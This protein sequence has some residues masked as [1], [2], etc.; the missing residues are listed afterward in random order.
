MLKD[1]HEENVQLPEPRSQQSSCSAL[2]ALVS[3]FVYF[4]LFWQATCKIS[5][6][7]LEWLLRFMFQFIHSLGVTCSNE[8]LIQMAAIFPSSLYLLRSIVKLDRDSFTKY[9]VCPDCTKLY[10]LDRCTMRV[11]NRIESRRCTNQP[12]PSKKKE[13]GALLARKVVTQQNNTVFYPFKVYCFNSVI[14]QL[15]SILKRPGMQSQCEKWRKRKV[16]HGFMADIF[17]GQMWKDFQTCQGKDFLRAKNN[18]A[19][20]INVDWFQP[21]KRRKDRSVGVIYFVILNLPREERYKWENVIVTGIIPELKKEPKS[22]NTFL[23]P[24]V[25]E[26]NALW[27]GIRLQTSSSK[28]PEHYRA[29][30]ILASSDIPASRKLCGFKGHSAHRGCSKCFKFFPGSF[31]QKTDYSGF[32]VNEW[33]LRDNQSHRRNALKVKNAQNKT[34]KEKLAKKY[35]VYFS[36][37]LDLEYFDAVRFSVVDPMHNLFLG[38]SKHIFKTWIKIGVLDNKALQ[39]L[40]KRILQCDVPTGHGRLPNKIASNYGCYTASQWKNWTLIYSIYCLKGLIPD[41]HFKCWQT[42]VLA[43]QHMSKHYICRNDIVLADGLFIKFCKQVEILFGKDVITPNM[44]LHCHMKNCVLDYGPLHAFWCFSFE[45]FN[46]ILGA[47]QMNGRSI[48]IQ[49]MRKF[50]TSKF[51]W[52][53]ELP[54]QFHDTFIP[55]FKSTTDIDTEFS[56]RIAV[57]FSTCS[58]HHN[59]TEVKWDDLQLVGLAKSFQYTILDSDDLNLLLDCY[60]QLHNNLDDIN[61]NCLSSTIRKYSYIF[62]GTEKFGSKKDNKSLR[63]SRVM[64]CWSDEDGKINPSAIARPGQVKYYFIHSLTV[65]GSTKQFAFASVLWHSRDEDYAKYG[66]PSMIWRQNE[67]DDPG[68]ASFM[69]VQRIACS[70]AQCSITRNNTKKIVVTPI[71]RIYN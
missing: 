38:T 18:L 53:S 59:L 58:I 25:N 70:F 27:K 33:P 54:K 22:L 34:R 51:T 39:E 69:P 30:V 55:F 17:D 64:A 10:E 3:W 37:L 63:S 41:E 15:E 20:G 23:G 6:N 68:P 71:S 28:T 21:Y 60:K 56:D 57:Y 48:E 11:G 45:R 9:A 5:D 24:V 8:Q 44:H 61:V 14:D 42:Y 36:K 2:T 47:T 32:D 29:A 7:G 66:N 12:F 35:G 4:I 1:I 43:C 13:C 19:L 50:I 62:L 31:G 16:K 40:E 49:L 46:G 26:L 67:F 65:R 52:N